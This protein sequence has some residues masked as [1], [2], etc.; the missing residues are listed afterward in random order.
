MLPRKDPSQAQNRLQLELLAMQ[1][2]EETGRVANSQAADPSARRLSDMLCQSLCCSPLHVWSM[3]SH[4]STL[5]R[6]ALPTCA[7]KAHDPS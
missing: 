3:L 2:E 7:C 4:F 1:M 6:L 5:S